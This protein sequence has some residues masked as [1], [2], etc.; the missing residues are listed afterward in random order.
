MITQPAPA[1]EVDA[2]D[3]A[4]LIKASRREPDRFAEIFERHAEE[5]YRYIARRLGP[6]S[7]NDLMSETFLRAFRQ[8][9]KYDSRFTDARPWLYGIATNLIRRHRRSEVRFY[10]AIARTGIDPAA[11]PVLEAVDDRLSA[12]SL[13]RPLAAALARLN[14][15]E[16]DVLVLLSAGLAYKEVAQALDVTV[17]TVSSRMNRARKKMSTALKGDSDG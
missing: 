11:E 17:G 5:I 3:D 1:A 12:E 8:R 10:R 14:A 2:T 13:R 6:D 16:R 9:E 4:T 15:G 7:G